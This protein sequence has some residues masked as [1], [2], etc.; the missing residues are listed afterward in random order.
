MKLVAQT[1]DAW[2]LAWLHSGRAE[3]LP[4]RIAP[5]LA[6]CADV[7]RDPATIELTVGQ[8]IVIPGFEDQVGSPGGI[9]WAVFNS[10]AELAAEWRAFADQGVG[11]LIVWGLPHGEASAPFLR[12]ALLQ[13]QEETAGSL[14]GALAS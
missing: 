7:G 12:D 4:A 3:E 6:A 5:L 9:E 1:A 10:P 13:F 14:V 11:H 8:A 2:N